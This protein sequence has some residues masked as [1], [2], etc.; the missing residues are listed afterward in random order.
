[1]A[2]RILVTA[3][4]VLM[5]AI[6][7]WSQLPDD[8]YHKT[9]PPKGEKLL[10]ILGKGQLWFAENPVQKRAY[11]AAAANDKVL[12]QLP[13]KCHCSRMGHTSL[14]TCFETTHGAGCDVCMKE[15]LYAADQ[16]AK[17]KTA[18]QIR[19]GIN[20]S[21]FQKIDLETGSLKQ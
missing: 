7:S 11:E 12:Y 14:R 6:G 4:V 2:R 9:P 8:A 13:C 5:A 19:D 20:R 21:E 15:A 10:P 1:L 17:G 3:I 16:T 18:S